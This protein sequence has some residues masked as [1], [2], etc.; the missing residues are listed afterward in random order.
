MRLS[1]SRI[2]LGAVFHLIDIGIGAR[3]GGLKGIIK[4][5][6]LFALLFFAP[7]AIA[8]MA[9]IISPSIIFPFIFLRSALARFAPFIL[10]FIIFFILLFIIVCRIGT[11]IV[12]IRHS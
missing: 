9:V 5:F 2:R 6:E 1:C 7:F 8:V 12:P 11:V 4:P 3:K 10:N